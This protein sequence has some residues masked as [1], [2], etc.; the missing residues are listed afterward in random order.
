VIADAATRSSIVTR[1]IPGAPV[2][3]LRL[4]LPGGSR[5]EAIPGQALVA[6]RMLAEGTAGRD[7]HALA[8]LAERRGMSIAGWSSLEAHGVEIDALRSEWERALELAAE[9]V[10]AS[11]FPADRLR[12]IARHAAAELAAQEDQA[13]VM[14]ARAFAEQLW[15]AHPKGRP[16]QGDAESLAR[17]ERT[18]CRSFHR[19]A[20]AR[21]GWLVVAGDIDPDAVGAAAQ[22]LFGA[23]GAPADD[24]FTPPAP[25]PRAAGR[26]EVRTRARDQ[27][28]LLVG[29]R[30]VGR[31]HPDYET[32][33][34]AAVALGA[35]AG[36]SGRIPNRVRDREGLAYVASAGLVNGAGLDAGH[37]SA[38]V[39]TG[40]DNVGRAERAIREEL[41]RFV[42]EGISAS[43]LETAKSYLLGREPFRRET[44]RQ[45]A[46]LA[47]Q[48]LVVG[49]P[50][51]DSAW[52]VERLAAVTRDEVGAALVRHLEIDALAV[53]VGLPA[54]G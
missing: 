49:L 2:V 4:V 53:T 42:A 13:D 44:A 11:D 17:L 22:E 31:R 54:A 8:D 9:L 50:L 33:E 45:W 10:F 30:T 37:C 6:G 40:P 46:D 43:E 19:E 1:R 7:W 38:Y 34:L 5:R 21:G 27:A 48:A 41:E 24:A 12:W 18:T 52:R 16:L 26:R 23:L 3:A 15:A 29:Q 51:T 25:P 39:G 35:G 28:H 32:L 14:T 47:A 36:L 20:L